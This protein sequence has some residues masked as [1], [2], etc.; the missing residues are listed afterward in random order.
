MSMVYA[1]EGFGAMFAEAE[2]LIMEH[3]AEVGLLTM[4]VN[5]RPDV[6]HYMVLQQAGMMHWFTMRSE[7]PGPARGR[8]PGELV[9]YAMWFL[10]PA[11]IFGGVKMAANEAIYVRP[12]QRYYAAGFMAFCEGE[13]RKAGARLL[14]YT[15]WADKEA[16]RLLERRGFTVQQR[17]Y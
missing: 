2:P 13:M 14:T 16:A 10:V 4:P 8:G 7:R 1:A 9:G 15:M 5:F 11:L 17:T 12:A 3:A 6:T